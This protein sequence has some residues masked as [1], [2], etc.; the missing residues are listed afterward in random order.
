MSTLIHFFMLLVLVVA[1]VSAGEMGATP[2]R[3]ITFILGEDE[4]PSLPV[5]RLAEMH[6][7]GDPLDRTND[8]VNSARSLEAVRDHLIQ[9]AP[10]D[11]NPWGLVN[12]VVHGREGLLDVPIKSGAVG[13]TTENLREALEKRPFEPI[14]D[15]LLDDRSEIRIHGCD[16]GRDP[17]LLGYLS[18]LFGGTDPL[19]P[20]VRGSR[21]FT[22]FQEET[23]PGLI[24]QRFL[25][26]AWSLVFRPGERP[27]APNL[28]A[29]F[30]ARFPHLD[31][32]VEDA[33]S[34]NVSRSK[35]DSF[36]YESG[37]RFKWTLVCPS[38][39]APSLPRGQNQILVWVR[40]QEDLLKHLMNLGVAP[41]DLHWELSLA[42][43]NHHGTEYPAI[44]ALGLGR[45]VY[46]LRS[47]NLPD[48]ETAT[49][50]QDER[51][52]SAVR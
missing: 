30:K 16:V 12:L 37:M 47:L 28:A 40:A 36:S 49:V 1:P 51:C 31:V 39:G 29:R 41:E 38:A 48:S 42:K 24:P 3:S 46:V 2:R 15:A 52:F 10:R 50:F 19:R 26:E 4:D 11:G 17:L 9:Q 33:L 13:A 7:R 32:K 34:R 25:T 21:Y 5:Y 22:C 43:Y 6:F 27:S 14:P 23:S 18:R 35:G 8:V 20:L 44:S 45:R